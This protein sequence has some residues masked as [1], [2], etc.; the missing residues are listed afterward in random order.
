MVCG[1]WRVLT[2]ENDENLSQDIRT[3]FRLG[4]QMGHVEYAGQHRKVDLQYQWQQ[5]TVYLCRKC[6]CFP[7][8]NVDQVPQV[9]FPTDIYMKMYCEHISHKQIFPFYMNISFYKE[10]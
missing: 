3:D 4:F 2:E 5:I 9:D 10:I 6:A 7:L 8:H 1:R